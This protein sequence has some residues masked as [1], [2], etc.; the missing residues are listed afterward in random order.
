[1]KASGYPALYQ[2]QEYLAPTVNSETGI[3][4]ST[5]DIVNE[6]LAGLTDLYESVEAWRVT[7]ERYQGALAAG[8]SAAASMQ[9]NQL[10]I[11]VDAAASLAD[12]NALSLALAGQ[13]LEQLVGPM[14]VTQQDV[15]DYQNDIAQHGFS[16]EAISILANL[17][18]TQQEIDD[19][20]TEIAGVDPATVPSDVFAAYS[21]SAA[22]VITIGDPLPA[23]P[24]ASPLTL[25]LL[26]L[27]IASVMTLYQRRSIS[28]K[29]TRS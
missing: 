17:H 20:Q 27:I 8:D 23:V 11:Y 5:V 24:S 3:P 26:A 9:L 28:Q 25:G 10:A 4:T 6:A 14:T 1:M 19:L 12:L 22:A 7:L 2:A 16:A 15:T 21:Q 29:P 18:P 13:A